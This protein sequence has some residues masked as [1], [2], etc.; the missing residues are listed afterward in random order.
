[1]DEQQ[2]QQC[3]MKGHIAWNRKECF[4]RKRN[5]ISIKNKTLMEGYMS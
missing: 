1:M 3:E 5:L 4:K 2:K